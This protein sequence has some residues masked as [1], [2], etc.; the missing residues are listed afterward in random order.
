MKDRLVE[1]PNR[2]RLQ[3]VEGEVGVYDLRPL[4]G[5]VTEEGTALN[6]VNIF[7]DV[8]SARY[9]LNDGTP[10]Q[11]FGRAVQV[12]YATVSRADWSET[13]NSDGWYTN[14]I[15]INEMREAY[16]PDVLLEITSAALAEDERTA[17]SQIMEFET[18]DGYVIAKTLDVPDIDIN[19][20]FE[21]V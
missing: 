14:H 1:H 15:E 10:S 16:R 2:F 4:P 6:K 5:T 8:M 9:G 19:I 18:Y 7:D 17:F 13:V 11:A 3:A 12:L 21:G 20:R